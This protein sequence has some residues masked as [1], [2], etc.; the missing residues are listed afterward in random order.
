MCVELVLPNGVTVETV[1][2]LREIVGHVP[3]DIEADNTTCL[4]VVDFDQLAEIYGWQLDRQSN[5]FG[6]VASER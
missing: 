4:C 5:P 2:A 1:G 6:I 3:T